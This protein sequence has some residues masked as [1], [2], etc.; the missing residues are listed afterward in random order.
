MGFIALKHEGVNGPRVNS[1]PR[2]CDNYFLY[3]M[4]TATMDIAQNA[5]KRKFILLETVLQR[6]SLS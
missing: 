4:G 6:C 2:A 1:V 3:P 5:R